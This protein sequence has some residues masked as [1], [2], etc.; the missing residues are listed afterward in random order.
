MAAGVLAIG[1]LPAAA[2]GDPGLAAAQR[3]T[4]ILSA[5]RSDSELRGYDLNVIAAAGGVVLSGTVDDDARR[6]RA[7]RVALGAIGVAAVDNR[8]AVDAAT[9]A[10]TD[11]QAAAVRS[12]DAAITAAIESKLQWN[13]LTDGL[14]VRVSTRAGRVVLAGS[15]ISYAERDMAGVVAGDTDGVAGVSNELVLADGTRP[16]RRA[17][18]SGRADGDPPSDAWISSKVKS[19]LLYTRGVSR[20]P[21]AVTTRHGVV[22]LAGVVAS[23]ADRDLALR[24]AQDVR[25]VREVDADGLTVG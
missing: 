25:G 18:R 22:S 19:S 24:V 1:A 4:R 2:Q 21:I 11:A 16:A 23:K 9:V 17:P 5:W 14:D 7:E 3:E 20:F 13:A 12:G 8:I 10:N 15:A 6:A